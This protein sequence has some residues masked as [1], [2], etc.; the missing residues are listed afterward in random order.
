MARANTKARLD[1]Q[2]LL[3]AMDGTRPSGALEWVSAAAPVVTQA[4]VGAGHW[5][6]GRRQRALA[7]WACA[8]GYALAAWGRGTEAPTHAEMIKN[9]RQHRDQLRE[10]GERLPPEAPA[11]AG[12]QA[13]PPSAIAN[14]VSALASCSQMTFGVRSGLRHPQRLT[15][16]AIALETFYAALSVLLAARAVQRRRPR[17]AAGRALYAAGSLARLR[18][19]SAE[20]LR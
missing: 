19:V 9:T 12:T 10:L 16:R 2:L 11:T 14:T 5:A 8:A 3:L 1:L 4:A 7:A 6:A 15:V 13:H 18:A 20:P 17:I